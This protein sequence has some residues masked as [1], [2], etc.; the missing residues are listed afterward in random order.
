MQPIADMAPPRPVM[1]NVGLTFMLGMGKALGAGLGGMP[2]N[3]NWNST[4]SSNSSSYFNS[5]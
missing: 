2:D 5:P 3:T 4:I 1:Q